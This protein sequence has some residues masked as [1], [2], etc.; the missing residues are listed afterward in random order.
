MRP[1]HVAETYDPMTH[2]LLPYDGVAAVVAD[3]LQSH[4]PATQTVLDVA[5][6]TGNL[7]LPLAKAGFGMTGL[8]YS[9][10]MLAVAREKAAAQGLSVRW[11]CQDMRQPIPTAPVDA[12]TCFYGGLNFLND[13]GS[14]QRGL[15]AVHDALRPG[16]LFVFDVFAERKLRAA[17]SGTQAADFGDFFVVTR[18]ACDD[19]GQVTHHVTFFLRTEDGYRREDEAHHLRLHSSTDYET[20]LAEAGFALRAVEPLYP[21]LDAPALRDVA[22]WIA[23]KP[24]A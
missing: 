12:A 14:L 9:P 7:T 17:F 24:A 11:L 23:Q 2:R 1:Y 22:L 3:Q 15:A 5:C 16:G 21:R 6:G 18:S 13:L 19:A 8:D 20:A 10:E 4:A